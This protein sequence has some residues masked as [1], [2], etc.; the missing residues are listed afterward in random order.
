[1]T[2]TFLGTCSGTEPMPG[3]K[4]VSFTIERNGAVY[5]FDAGESC[6]YTA[7]LLG[8]DLLA[9]RAI[10][11]THCHMDHIGGLP[12]L[13]WTMRKLNGIAPDKPLSGRTVQ[14]YLPNLVTWMGIQQLLAGTEGG[15]SLD[16]K[17]AASD[18][19]DGLIFRDDGFEVT[20]LHNKHLGPPPRPN[21]WQSFSFQMEADGKSVVFSGDVEDIRELE[22]LLDDCDLLLMGTGHHEVEDLCSYLRSSGKTVRQLGFLHHGR[23]ILDDPEGE[24][25]KARALFGDSVFLADD[26]MTMEM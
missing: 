26:G 18:F 10:F 1:M 23:D 2:L 4:H 24:L 11:I 8:I 21:Q 14:V 22:S 15:F 7:H 19:R 17:L 12:N 13:L 6:S 20:A 3:R 25:K 5:W 9:V 16:Y